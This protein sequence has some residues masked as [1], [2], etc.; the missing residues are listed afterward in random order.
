MGRAFAEPTGRPEREPMPKRP[1]SKGP[2]YDLATECYAKL[3]VNTEKALAE[4]SEVPIS[5]HC[6]QGDD[7]G[8]FENAGETLGGGLAV[9]GNYPGKAR[10]PEELRSDLDKA[11]SLIPGKHRLNL[12]SS[13]AET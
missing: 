10:T 6:W 5:L 13:Y 9:T 2:A 8:G 3:E 11:F 12:H 7:V 4:L 1:E